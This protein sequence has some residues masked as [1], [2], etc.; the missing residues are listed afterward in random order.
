MR[1]AIVEDQILVGDVLEKLCA[2]EFRCEIVARAALGAA[3]AKLILATSPELVLLDLMLPDLDGFWVV[4]SV[5]QG[6]GRPRILAISSHCDEF[7]AYRVERR[8]FE[9]FVDKS[10]A[11]LDELRSALAAVMEGG[12]YYSE[13]FLQVQQRRKQDPNAFDKILTE[14]E[15][16]VLIMIAGLLSDGEIA[17]RLGISEQTAQK[18]R[19]NISHK[20]GLDSRT[21]LIRYAQDRGM[22]PLIPAPWRHK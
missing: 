19:F 2:D 18:H 5:R 3:A 7:T 8:Q 22:T 4:D 14:R 1:V 10:S 16:T 11:M 13:R 12:T 20:L 15:Q 17:Q 6:G 9:G 21:L